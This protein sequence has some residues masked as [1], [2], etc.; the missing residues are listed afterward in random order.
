RPRAGRSAAKATVTAE[1]LADVVRAEVSAV[2]GLGNP[3]AVE[4]GRAFKEIGFDSLTS[5]ELRNRLAAATG[6]RLPAT[7]LFDHP[8]PA[9]VI[10]RLHAELAGTG[11]T[12]ETATPAAVA[13]DPVVIVGMACRF[14]GGVTSPDELWQLV[15]DGRDAITEFPTDRGWDAEALY[16]ADPDRPGRTYTTRGG[17]LHDAGQFDAEFFGI[18]P[19]EATAMDPQQRLLLETSWEA[20]EN[21]G[22]DPLG[23]RGSRTGVFAGAMYHDYTARLAPLPEEAEGYSF[24]GGSGSVVSGRVAYTFGFE[25]PAVTVDTACSS[26]LVAL[27]LAAQ[28]LRQGECGLALAGGV[29]VMATPGSFVEFSRQRALAPDGR[30]KPFAAAADGTAWAEGAG[31][32]L[33]ERL[34]DARRNG[35]PVLAVLRGS[36][37]NSDGASNGLTAPNGPSQQR[38]IRAALATAGLTPSDVDAVEAHGTGTPLGD[39]IEAQALLETYGQDRETPLWLGSLKSNVGHTQAA[40]GVGAVVKVVQAMRHGVLPATL[41][42]DEPSPHVDWTAG[43]VELLTENRA[44]PEV[45]RPRRAAVSSFGISGTNAHVILE[46]VP[47]PAPSAAVDGPVPWVLSARNEPALREQ[48]RQLLPFVNGDATAVAR[49]LV[50]RSAFD[51]RAVVTDDLKAGLTALAERGSGAGVARPNRRVVF[52]FPGQGSQWAGMGRELLAADPVFAARMAECADALRSFVDWELL[53]VLDDAEALQR[54]DVVQPALWAMMVSLAAVWRAHG[55]EP[56]AVVGHSQ[57]EIAAA[58]VAG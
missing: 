22:I 44:W 26:S 51:H 29:A 38:V 48:A 13:G 3:A 46:A 36:A 24:T 7:L 17:F 40:A 11:E 50:K 8:T 25:G 12:A 1:G 18:S 45:T 5:V 20:F 52:V 37:I 53:D 31:M 41:H 32:L 39:P 57:G 16:D 35:H 56:A 6:L 55:V 15:V 58:V 10:D 23:L 43:A 47:E 28:A 27:H 14:P 9:A 21:A 54:V 42:V 34:S 49:A 19:R 33:L 4:P 2:L 30:C